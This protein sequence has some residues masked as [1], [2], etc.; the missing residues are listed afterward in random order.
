M[1]AILFLLQN[2]KAEAF[3]YTFPKEK[4]SP[5]LTPKLFHKRE[6]RFA[7]MLY[8][9]PIHLYFNAHML[10]TWKSLNDDFY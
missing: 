4:L 9:H 3:L 7:F 8:P 5:L 10:L 2:Q 6:K 1:P